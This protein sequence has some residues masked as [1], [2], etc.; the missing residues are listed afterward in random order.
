M[1]FANSS[2]NPLA[3]SGLSQLLGLASAITPQSMSAS[4]T[5][6]A[7]GGGGYGGVPAGYGSG[8]G[9]MQGGYGMPAGYGSGYAGSPTTVYTVTQT[10][11]QQ[12]Y[13]GTYPADPY[14]MTSTMT[15]PPQAGW[16]GG[17]YPAGYY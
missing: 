3:A 17:Y 16:G 1:S 2:F 9:G 8:Y 14:G 7:Y 4:S 5:Y 11:Y 12:A 13:Y 15:M 10:T 6:G